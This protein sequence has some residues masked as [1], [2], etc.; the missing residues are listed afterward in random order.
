MAPDNTAAYARQICCSVKAVYELLAERLKVGAGT[1]IASHLP[2]GITP[3]QL[4]AI[5]AIRR[6]T[7][8]TMTELASLLGV[9]VASAS[10]MVDR[11]VKKE[12]LIR[13][14]VPQDRRKVIARLSP[15]IEQDFKQI[16]MAILSPICRLIDQVNPETVGIWCDMLERLRESLEP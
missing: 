16:E 8:V 6:R 11:L 7:Q 5:S 1:G 12:I 2:I 3:A 15:K 14:I 9:S 13:E 10:A 4:Q